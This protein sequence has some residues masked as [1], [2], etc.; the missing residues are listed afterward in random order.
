MWQF[1]LHSIFS[2]IIDAQKLKKKQQQ[3]ILKKQPHKYQGAELK[4]KIR[5]LLT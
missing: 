2:F 4:F 3:H 1:S 5:T